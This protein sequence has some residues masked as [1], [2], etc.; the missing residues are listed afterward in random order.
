MAYSFLAS[1]SKFINVY[2]HAKLQYT[3]ALRFAVVD[4][5][6]RL[7]ISFYGDRKESVKTDRGN[8][9]FH[10]ELT[11]NGH[12]V[13][14][15]IVIGEPRTNGGYNL[16]TAWYDSDSFGETNKGGAH[17][18]ADCVANGRDVCSVQHVAGF[19]AAYRNGTKDSGEI[20]EEWCREQGRKEISKEL[21]LLLN[22][23]KE[24]YNAE[25]Q[26]LKKENEK[27]ITENASIEALLEQYRQE[28]SKRHVAAVA[29]AAS[30]GDKIKFVAVGAWKGIVEGDRYDLLMVEGCEPRKLKWSTFD[31]NHSVRERA[32]TIPVGTK[33]GL[34]CWDPIAEPGRWSNQGFC[35][36]VIVI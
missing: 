12:K 19:S 22:N 2:R 11:I 28:D 24:R 18:F 7:E 33:V 35:R 23:E 15:V 20:L 25:V 9:A 3:F 10:G 8:V 13:N 16:V 27:L 4:V 29:K 36:D 1:S 31:S 17:I 34:T 30:Q 14:N 5:S 21:Q 26:K 6:D 32:K